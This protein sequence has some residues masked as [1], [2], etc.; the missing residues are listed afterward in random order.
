MM[1]SAVCRVISPWQVKRRPQP[2]DSSLVQHC[3]YGGD[4]QVGVWLKTIDALIEGNGTA[5][6]H[7]AFRLMFWTLI[8]IA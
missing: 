6:G 2:S 1:R 4:Q 3:V 7:A 8:E 5:T